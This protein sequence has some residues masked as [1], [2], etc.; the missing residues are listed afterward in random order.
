MASNIRKNKYI[1]PKQVY[2]DVKQTF[3]NCYTFNPPGDFVY[4]QGKILDA[5]FEDEWEKSGFSS[6]VK[7]S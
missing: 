6:Q 5:Y 1:T 3:I 4:E 2:D 7:K